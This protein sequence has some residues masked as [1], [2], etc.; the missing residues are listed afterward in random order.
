MFDSFV[1]WT[2]LW[3]RDD[4]VLL[5]MHDGDC[6]VGD[7]CE[8]VHQFA[9]T[10][11]HHTPVSRETPEKQSIEKQTIK[12]TNVINQISLLIQETG[13]DL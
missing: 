12:K 4:R 3:Y 6:G 11:V 1:N 13:L 8:Q 9:H 2:S 10:V 5:L 7:L